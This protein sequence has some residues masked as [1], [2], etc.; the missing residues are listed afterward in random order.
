MLA[1]DD[2]RGA[3]LAVVD[4]AFEESLKRLGLG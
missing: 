3:I 1:L 2:P 4:A